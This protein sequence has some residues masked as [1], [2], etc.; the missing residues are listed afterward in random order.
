MITGVCWSVDGSF[1]YSC[2]TDMDI[3]QWYNNFSQQLTFFLL[4]FM[5]QKNKYYFYTHLPSKKQY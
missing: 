4:G 1:V 3:I 5:T 2:S